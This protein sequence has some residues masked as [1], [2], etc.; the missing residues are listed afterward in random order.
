MGPRSYRRIELKARRSLAESGNWRVGI[1]G[2][3][4]LEVEVAGAG[5]GEGDPQGV[6]LVHGELEVDLDG[7][8]EGLGEGSGLV[9]F[10]KSL[11]D[12]V[13]AV[14]EVEMGLAGL[15]V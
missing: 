1:G 5:F 14:G 8:S 11:D 12:F 9:G 6:E 13:E 10:E 7:R 4:R 3:E 2:G 15:D